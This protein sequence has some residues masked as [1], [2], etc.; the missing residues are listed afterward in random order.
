MIVVRCREHPA[1]EVYVTGT[2]DDWARSVKLEKQR[3]GSF[4]KLVDLPSADEKIA[5]KVRTYFR[6]VRR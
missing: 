4:Q 6:F 3:D 2:F 1:S 5:Y